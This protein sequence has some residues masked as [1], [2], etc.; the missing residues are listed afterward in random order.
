MLQA[1]RQTLTGDSLGVHENEGP[2]LAAN[3]DIVARET[4]LRD[5]A[6]GVGAEANRAVIDPRPGS[7]VVPAGCGKEPFGVKDCHAVPAAVDSDG[8]TSAQA[9]DIFLPFEIR[10]ERCW[11]VSFYI[12]HNPTGAEGI[13]SKVQRRGIVGSWAVSVQLGSL[14][15]NTQALV[16][17]RTH[18]S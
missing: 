14:P 3:M 10:P 5:V 9:R 15:V 12:V 17:L 11:T 16:M 18:V 1:A 7:V 4:A 13:A 6:L 8:V 2:L